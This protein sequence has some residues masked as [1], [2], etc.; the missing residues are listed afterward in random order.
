[1][2]TRCELTLTV[3]LA[4]YIDVADMQPYSAR[5][6]L[7]LYERAGQEGE[8]K[9]YIGPTEGIVIAVLGGS[10]KQKKNR[11]R[12]NVMTLMTVTC[13]IFRRSGAT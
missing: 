12:V 4:V 2:A 3:I 9:C 10:N 13:T 7:R 1:M 5:S 11:V 6:K 8:R